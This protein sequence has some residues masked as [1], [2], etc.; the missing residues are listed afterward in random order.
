MFDPLEKKQILTIHQEIFSHMLK[1]NSCVYDDWWIEL[2]SKGLTKSHA[3][4]VMFIEKKHVLLCENGIHV[5]ILLQT[6]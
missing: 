4:E 5:Y 2:R 3:K 6:G 1:H